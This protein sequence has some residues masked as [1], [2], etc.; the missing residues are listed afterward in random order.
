MAQAQ[1]AEAGER[2]SATDHKSLMGS[3]M[4]C[5]LTICGQ[6]WHMIYH[7]SAWGLLW[8]SFLSVLVTM[9]VPVLPPPPQRSRST[10]QPAWTSTCIRA[11]GFQRKGGGAKDMRVSRKPKNL[12]H[13][14]GVASRWEVRTQ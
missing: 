13:T 5:K 6:L 1:I 14:L 8:H 11:S 12:V 2:R 4:R 10:I 7:P 9:A 3:I